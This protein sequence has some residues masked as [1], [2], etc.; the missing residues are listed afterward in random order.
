MPFI[1]NYTKV[2]MF[3]LKGFLRSKFHTPEAIDKTKII[4]LEAIKDCKWK[5]NNKNYQTQTQ[6]TDWE[7]ESTACTMKKGSPNVQNQSGNSQQTNGQ[8]T[9]THTERNTKGSVPGADISTTFSVCHLS[10][11]D[12]ITNSKNSVSPNRCSINMCGIDKQ[13]CV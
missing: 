7:G 1:N 4:K 10:V 6:M 13:Q 12:F 9:R 8:S 11:T 5:L 3:F 2:S